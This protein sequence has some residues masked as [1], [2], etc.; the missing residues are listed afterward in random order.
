[1]SQ[2]TALD[3]I[4]AVGP[5]EIPGSPQ[6]RGFLPLF[7][8]AWFGLSI[9]L[10]TLGSASIP[11]VFAFLD[12]ATKGLH[13][14]IV[15]AIGGIVVMVVTPLFGRMS[16]RTMSRLGKRRPWILGGAIAGL[17]GVLVLAV[18]TELWQV[19]V[20]WSIVQ[21]GYGATNSAVHALLADQI[22]KRTRA[23]VSAA[24]SAAN[25]FALIA[26]SLIIAALPNDQ[27]WAWFVVP[28]A[29]GSV[30]SALLFLRLRDIVRTDPPAPWHWSD[31]LSTYW[32]NPRVYRDFFW[33]FACRL[34]VTM[35]IVT[36]TLYLLFIIIDRLGVSKEEASASFATI[37]ILFTLSS[38]VTSIA[39]AIVSDRTGRRKAIVWVSALLSAGGLVVALMAPDMSVFLVAMALVGAAQGAFV[40]VDVAMMTE[41]LPTFDEA[42]KDLGI[43]SLSYQIPQVLVPV[44]AI[45]L[46]AIGGGENYSALFV[47][48]IVFG[49]LGGLAVLPIKG[50][51]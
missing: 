21:I 9:V 42:G 13:L 46:L 39:F 10:G 25:A 12:D 28:G 48:A 17:A 4:G 18:S 19:I 20:G 1:M 36:V 3:P 23:R 40:S 7:V 15:A 8:L 6:P 31:V 14:S 37:L 34:L 30:C 41:V 38:I 5:D 35:S 47:A 45:P 49:V 26:G 22:P 29:I 27:Q 2:T 44:V 51:R 32:L 11:K 16:D 24:A 33:A 43:V 50:V